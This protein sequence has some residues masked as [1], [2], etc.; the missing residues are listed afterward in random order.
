MNTDR[1]FRGSA[2]VATQYVTAR[3]T[4]QRDGADYTPT[5]LTYYW[6]PVSIADILLHFSQLIITGDLKMVRTSVHSSRVGCVPPTCWRIPGGCPHTG[7]HPGGSAHPPPPGLPKGGSASRGLPGGSASKG[8]LPGPGLPTRGL[9]RP[10][11]EQNGTG[12]KTLSC[13]R[14]LCGR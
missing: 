14:L 5:T 12:V 4:N 9:G 8:V 1:R 13:S 6:R 7:L 10:P 2:S 11:R 3:G